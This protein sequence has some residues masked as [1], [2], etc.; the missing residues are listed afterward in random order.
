MK[1]PVHVNAPKD[2]KVPPNLKDMFL[3]LSTI[4]VKFDHIK[5][6]PQ[7]WVR[8]KLYI[9]FLQFPALLLGILHRTAKPTWMQK[10]NS[11]VPK[12][13]NVFRCR[14]WDWHPPRNC[15]F[16]GCKN[17][18]PHINYR[19]AAE[20][21]LRGGGIPTIH[22]FI[23]GWHGHFHLLPWREVIADLIAWLHPQRRRPTL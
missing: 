21:Y 5:L 23:G 19:F 7:L 3:E 11:A 16:S 12:V 10:L 4:R 22:I 2:G 1:T 20:L 17:R 18:S 8:A 6:A 15:I 13:L 14:K 9:S